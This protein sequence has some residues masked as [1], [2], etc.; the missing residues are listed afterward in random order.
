MQNGICD[1]HTFSG[2]QGESALT[3]FKAVEACKCLLSAMIILDYSFYWYEKLIQDIN[4]YTFYYLYM[5]LR[6]VVI[7]LG[8]GSFCFSIQKPPKHVKNTFF[9]LLHQSRSQA[10][11]SSAPIGALVCQLAK[12]YQIRFILDMI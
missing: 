5:F 12:S 8:T 10:I 1:T 3:E 9:T 2:C 4:H 7:V 11:C 6:V